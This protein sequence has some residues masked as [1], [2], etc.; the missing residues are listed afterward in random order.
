MGSCD[1]PADDGHRQQRTAT[2]PGTLIA[3]TS[4]DGS[5]ECGAGREILRPDGV[6]GRSTRPNDDHLEIAPHARRTTMTSR[7]QTARQLRGTT[8]GLVGGLVAVASLL[9]IRETMATGWLE[10][11]PGAAVAAGAIGLG[12]ML[13]PR[14]TRSLNRMNNNRGALDVRS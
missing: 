9:I 7:R 12:V 8:P 14:W 1:G 11:I 3:N 13:V 10:L 6:Q 5:R 2:G 4:E